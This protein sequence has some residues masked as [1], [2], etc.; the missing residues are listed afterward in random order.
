MT[1]YLLIKIKIP[2]PDVKPKISESI[3]HKAIIN[4]AKA[5]FPKDKLPKGATVEYETVY[6]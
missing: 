5:R 4:G 1:K 2:L 6:G 3:V